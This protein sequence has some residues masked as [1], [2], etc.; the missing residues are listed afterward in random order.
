MTADWRFLYWAFAPTTKA[1]LGG[2][3]AAR[4]VVVMRERRRTVSDRIGLI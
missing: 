3:V 4:I 1:P 2:E